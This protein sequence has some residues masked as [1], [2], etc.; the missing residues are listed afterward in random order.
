MD[1]TGILAR[2][3]WRFLCFYRLCGLNDIKDRLDE[4]ANLEE[5][6]ENSVLEILI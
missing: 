3:L 5:D 2:A 1:G 6:C 4:F